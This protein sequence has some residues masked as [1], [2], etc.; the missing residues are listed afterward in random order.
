MKPGLEL[1]AVIVAGLATSCG[2]TL[3]CAQLI[4][5]LADCAAIKVTLTD[6]QTT[7]TDRPDAIREPGKD[8]D[9]MY[10][11]GARPV[12]WVRATQA[13]LKSAMWAALGRIPPT[14]RALVVEGTSVI[15]CLRA[16]LVL[17]AAP[18]HVPDDAQIKP[19]RLE[20]LTRADLVVANTGKVGYP[21][22]PTIGEL[23]AR[24]A[25][26][27]PCVEVDFA[28]R[29]SLVARL[30]PRFAAAGLPFAATTR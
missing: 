7:I 3:L 24:H 2:K 15:D 9:R 25:V 29:D 16:S 8:T 30:A 18:L 17:F 11:A 4:G 13:D 22:Q 19:Y 5:L 14:T 10:T 26:R 27:A 1:P 12:V 21:L 28:D 23:C 6:H 20:A